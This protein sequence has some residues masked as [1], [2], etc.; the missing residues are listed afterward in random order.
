MKTKDSRRRF[1]KEDVIRILSENLQFTD[2][3]IRN[4]PS[5]L[6]HIA[7]QIMRVIE[8]YIVS[9]YE[10]THICLYT[11]RC[12]PVNDFVRPGD[13]LEV[14]T[15]EVFGQGEIGLDYRFD[16]MKKDK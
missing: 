3:D 12:N 8:R 5:V 4:Y 6:E 10:G 13:I 9:D 15:I 2:F 7:G 14:K 16:L 11:N 1:I